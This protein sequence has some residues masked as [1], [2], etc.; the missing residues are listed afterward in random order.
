[1]VDDG[2]THLKLYK[3]ARAKMKHAKCKES[4]Q[5]VHKVSPS[6]KTIHK[7]NKSETDVSWYF[8]KS[9][10]F[11]K[12]TLIAIDTIWLECCSNIYNRK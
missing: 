12:G 7:R 9:I 3:Q 11:K 8:G 6:K 4:G 1:M 5:S 2:A 10:E